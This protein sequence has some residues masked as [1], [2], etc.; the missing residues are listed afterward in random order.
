M[1]A[2]NSGK[3]MPHK[4][5]VVWSRESSERTQAIVG[6]LRTEWG[7]REASNFLVKLKKFERRVKQFPN[8]YPASIKH[9]ELRKAVL[10]RYQSVIYEV[11]DDEVRVIT[12][13]EHRKENE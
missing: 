12:I 10:T 11:Y 2:G 7:E 6:Y 4:R 13:L 3:I 8:L 5:R 1:T 9:P